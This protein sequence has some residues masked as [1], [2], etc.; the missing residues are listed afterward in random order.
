MSHLYI[1][2][3]YISQIVTPVGG[4][5]FV[6]FMYFEIGYR[7]FDKIVLQSDFWINKIEEAWKARPSSGYQVVFC[8]I[9]SLAENIAWE[10]PR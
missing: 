9:E 3:K 7:F 1:Y 4:S 5:G 6:G 2:E 10:A 8:P